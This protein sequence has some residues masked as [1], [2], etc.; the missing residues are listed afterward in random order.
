[1]GRICANVWPMQFSTTLYTDV[2]NVGEGVSGYARLAV[3]IRLNA[4]SFQQVITLNVFMSG[5]QWFYH[6]QA[7]HQNCF[8]IRLYSPCFFTPAAHKMD[9][10]VIQ[11][12]LL[13]ILFST[14]FRT[15]FTVATFQDSNKK[16]LQQSVET[17]EERNAQHASYAKFLLVF[18]S[19][20]NSCPLLQGSSGEPSNVYNFYGSTEVAIDSNVTFSSADNSSGKSFCRPASWI[21]QSARL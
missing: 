1:M 4:K 5:L 19:R 12:R 21:W 15:I 16:L 2:P 3:C 14:L 7:I 6:Y 18:M 20:C 17:H 8:E 10:A 13:I 11:L 9:F